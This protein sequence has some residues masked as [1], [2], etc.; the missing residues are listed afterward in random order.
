MIGDSLV[1]VMFQKRL[2]LARE[3]RR[4]GALHKKVITA[5]IVAA[6]PPDVRRG[7]AG[8]AVCDKSDYCT[9]V[10]A[11]PPD[12]RR[13]SAAP[14]DHTINLGLRPWFDFTGWRWSLRR[15]VFLLAGILSSGR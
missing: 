10:A 2:G 8:K 3:I 7:F 12:V 4:G 6:M 14:V 9:I 15:S 13:G 11:M 1:C 5:P